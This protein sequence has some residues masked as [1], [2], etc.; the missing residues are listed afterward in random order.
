[1]IKLSQHCRTWRLLK[2]QFLYSLYLKSF[3]KYLIS[4]VGGTSIRVGGMAKGSGMIHPNM[5]TMLGVCLSSVSNLYFA[6]NYQLYSKVWSLFQVITTDA[7]VESDV[8][9]KMVRL[10]VSRSFNQITVCNFVAFNP[11]CYLFQLGDVLVEWTSLPGNGLFGLCFVFSRLIYC[12]CCRLMET[13]V[14]MIQS[15]LLPAGYPDQIGSLLW[16]FMKLHYFKL[17]LMQ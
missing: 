2:N 7:L 11:P 14:P 9:R 10:A 3:C 5:A 8:W 15:L 6:Y 13:P 16:P 17:V 4:Q 12:F 1:M